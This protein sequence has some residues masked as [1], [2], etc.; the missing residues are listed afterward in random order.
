MENHLETSGGRYCLIL[1]DNED[2]SMIDI[3]DKTS[4]KRVSALKSDEKIFILRH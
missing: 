3:Q 1:N 4:N 2:F